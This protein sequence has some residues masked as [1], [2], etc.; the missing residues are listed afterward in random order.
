MLKRALFFSTPFCLSLRNGQM[1]VHTKEA[2]DMQRS[3]PIE[4]IGV[5]VLEHQQTSVTL[6]LLNALSDN[7]VAVI[8]CGDNRM[9]NAMLMN[10]DSN[11]TQGEHYREQIEASEPL[12]KGLWRQIVEAK[13]RN[14]AALLHKLGRDGDKLK[15]F[16]FL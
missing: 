14:Q 5:V 10:L 12:K 15:S 8:L 16:S 3:V 13:I 11:K 1:I 4:D 7:N 6:P 9:P 2:P